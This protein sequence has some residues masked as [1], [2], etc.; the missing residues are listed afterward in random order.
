MMRAE[1]ISS[2]ESEAGIIASL[3]HKPELVYYSE[4]LLPKHFTNKENACV[5]AAIKDLV[6]R[7]IATIDPYNIMEDI[8][9]DEETRRYS[10]GITIEKLQ[11]LVEMSDVLARSSVEEY[12]LMVRNVLDSAFRRKAFQQLKECQVICYDRAEK[13]VEQQI[14]QRIDQVMSE[15]SVADEIPEFKDII[16]DLWEDVESHQDGSNF[17]TPFIFR[18]LNEYVT[19]D[20][21]E[22]VILGAPA[23]GAKSML[24]MN[25]AV[26]LIRQGK[27]VMY[28]DSE[29]SSRLFLCRML[30]HLTGIEFKRIKSGQYTDEEYKKIR[31]QIEWIK[32][33]RFVHV[34]MPIF[35]Q[36]AVYTAVKKTAHR[37]GTLD[38][39]ITDYL[40]ATG[41]T[42][43]YATYAE[44][45]KLTDMIKNDICGA[46]KIAGLA[47][48]QLTE[49]GKLA[50]SAKIARNASTILLLVDKTAE[51]IEEDGEECG[52]KKLIVSKNRNG[53][54][55]VQGEYIDIGFSGDQCTLYEAKQHIP[56][57]PY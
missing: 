10:D 34:Y 43:A 56:N 24:L 3:I 28:I 18:T 7:G 46:M 11:E 6:K 21:G 25:E 31:K 41:D 4:F 48:A 51:E 8:N 15:F 19:L 1:D 42:D 53:M 36:Q 22:L 20:P 2:I 32:Q 55:H 39:L 30:S 38:V 14:Y 50:D 49:G 16:D 27:S 23:K 54:Q 40:K 33:Q 26:D 9:A 44:L 35:E 37:F 13:N 17:G 47:A 57:S 12:K 29:L 52:T 5:Y 45:G